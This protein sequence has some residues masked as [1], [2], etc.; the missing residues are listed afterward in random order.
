MFKKKLLKNIALISFI[1]FIYPCFNAIAFSEYTGEMGTGNGSITTHINDVTPPD[2]VDDL[3]VSNISNY[4]LKLNW[5]ATGDDGN[6]GTASSYDIR[7]SKE[8]ITNENFDSATQISSP[9]APDPKIAGTAQSVEVNQ[10]E[11]GT[12]Y[13][14]AMKVSDEVPNE[15]E[16]SNVVLV[17][18]SVPSSGGGRISTPPTSSGGSSGGSNASS[19]NRTAN[20]VPLKISP[21]QKGT[22]NQKLN[23]K[24]KIKVEVPK[25]SVKSTTTF[26]ASA[27]SLKEEDVPKNK[28][29][30]FLFGGLVFNV[31]AKDTTGKNIR[32]FSKDL[33]ITL[34]VPNIPKDTT[35]LELYYFDDKTNEWIKITGVVFGK[36]TIT[37]KVNHLTQFALFETDVVKVGKVKGVTDI[38]VLDGDII[39]CQ[40]SDNPFAVYIVKVVGNTKYIRHIVSIDIF[41]YYGHLKWENL[42]QVDS[43]NNYSLSG[44]VRVNTGPN[45]TP[46]ATDK[47]YEINGDQTKHWINMTAEQFLQHGGSDEAIYTVNQGELDMYTTGPDVMM[48]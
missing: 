31:N 29:G 34:T 39:Q 1:M 10:L 48:L 27:G 12:T 47:V 38:N 26:T 9:S 17:T 2:A 40:S 23:N 24:N 33:T 3:E 30:A 35:N 11:Q 46:A 5:T 42:K 13:Y 20:N 15:S 45:G 18:T 37:F 7:Y 19:S 25:G 41:N 6:A 8:D 32:E 22:L 28:T 43:L 21:T 4:T 36:N 44:W 14:F 16:I